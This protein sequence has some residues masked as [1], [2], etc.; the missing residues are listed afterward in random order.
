MGMNDMHDREM[1]RMDK[2]WIWIDYAVQEI[3][4][5]L[6]WMQNNICTCS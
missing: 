5:A 1:I 6:S 3:Q 4:L 2:T